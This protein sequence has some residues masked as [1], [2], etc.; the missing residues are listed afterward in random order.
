MTE[1]R[2]RRYA[3][4]AAQSLPGAMSGITSSNQGSIN[5]VAKDIATSLRLLPAVGTDAVHSTPQGSR[6]SMVVRLK[7]PRFEKAMYA[8][9]WLG[10]MTR[11]PGQ[12]VFTPGKGEDLL[13]TLTTTM[14]GNDLTNA[15]RSVGVQDSVLIPKRTGMTAMVY[16][17]EA[18]LGAA[19]KSLS[20]RLKMG[21]RSEGGTGAFVGGQK[22]E[23]ARAAYRRFIRGYEAKLG[24][25]SGQPQ[26][27]PQQRQQTQGA[28]PD[29]PRQMRRRYARKVSK[30]NVDAMFEG[31]LG[32]KRED[33]PQIPEDHKEKFLMGLVSAGVGHTDHVMDPK[34]LK[35]SQCEW[36]PDALKR[37]AASY[38]AGGDERDK[39]VNNR[40]TVSN[41]GYVL[42]GHHR[43]ADAHLRGRKLRVVKIDLP[44]RELV[45]AAA[46]FGSEHG[47]ERK[48]A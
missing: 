44:I 20:S 7:S 37:V 1:Q 47:V 35:P 31:S 2:P 32:L 14:S 10:L 9:S 46:A 12:V 34:R 33:T 17:R 21:L 13:H 36:S 5:D 29:D 19:M 27:S 8:A 18:K 26:K 45:K 15:L 43:W 25:A 22:E 30:S 23:D 41:D 39:L 6:P 24:E 4:P 38:D 48:T 28:M 16:D 40:V 11:Q 3:A 42:D